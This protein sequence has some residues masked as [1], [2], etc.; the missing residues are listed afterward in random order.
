MT[1]KIISGGQ[2]GA[3]QGG[4][5]AAEQLGIETGGW[6][7]KGWKTEAGANPALGSRYGLQEHPATA[8]PPRTK[9]NILAADGTIVFGDVQSTGSRLTLD[10]CRKHHKPV[11][12]VPSSAVF[13]KRSQQKFSDWLRE[14]AVQ[15][16]NVAGNR[17]SKRPGLQQAVRDFLVEALKP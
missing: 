9:A 3:D 16:L 13:S 2:T 6:A 4:L 15:V 10:L 14:N 17:E 5:E 12:V 11:F 1:R 7:P 8:Y